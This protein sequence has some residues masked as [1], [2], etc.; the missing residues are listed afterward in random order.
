VAAATF[1]S[2]ASLKLKGKAKVGRTLKAV[3]SGSYRP[4]DVTTKFQ[5]YVNG[6]KIAGATKVTLK[7]KKSW[8][9]KFITVRM[10]TTKTGYATSTRT[11]YSAKVKK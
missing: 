10:T 7:V 5:W 1:A 2:T 9:G 11:A 4:G 8:K 3:K 6:V